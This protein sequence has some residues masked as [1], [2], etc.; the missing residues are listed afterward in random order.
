[1]RLLAT[2]VAGVLT[3]MAAPA[4]PATSEAPKFLVLDVRTPEE[5]EQ[6][7]AE[8]AVNLDFRE[9]GREIGRL[10]PDKKTAI[11]LYCLSG[12]RSG[13]ALRTLQ[14]LGYKKAENVGTLKAMK[15]RLRRLKQAEAG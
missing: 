10:A 1:M 4:E 2:L 3:A 12:A 5:F 11:Y 9:V 15:D 7:H 8:G 14:R 6:G 13:A